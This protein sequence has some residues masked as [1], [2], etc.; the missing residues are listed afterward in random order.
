MQFNKNV[1]TVTKE[2]NSLE[3]W[4]VLGSPMG[5]DAQWKDDRRAKELARY[6]MGSY[7]NLPAEIETVLSSFTT[8]D[9]AFDWK[10]EYVTSFAHFGYGTGNGRNHD[11]VIY[12]GDIF[13]GVE[14]KADEP[15]GDKTIGEELKKASDNKKKRIEKLVGLVFGDAVENHLDL[16]Y[17]LLTA[18]G[19]VLLEAEERKSKNAMLL[20]LVFLKA[21]TD[22]N[23]NNYYEEENRQRNNADWSEF[24]KQ[25]AAELQNGCCKIPTK[26]GIN[27]YA[28]KIEIAVP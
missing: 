20:V 3:S 7:P 27:L 14:A 22:A 6:I 17:Q 24:L 12:N 25:M 11:M 5:G 2:I 8:P 10:A 4:Q 1:V 19:G 28:Q 13:V 21:G 18:C 23:G 15:F 26:N 9:T 16:R